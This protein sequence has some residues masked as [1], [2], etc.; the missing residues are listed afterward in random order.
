[1]IF[2]T[3]QQAINQPKLRI[4]APVAL[5]VGFVLFYLLN[6]PFDV[7]AVSSGVPFVCVTKYWDGI[8]GNLLYTKNA[9]NFQALLG[10]NF[11]SVTN[12]SLIVT[13][14]FVVFMLALVGFGYF[15]Y[16]NRLNL[17]LLGTAFINMYFMFANNV[18]QIVFVYIF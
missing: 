17:L 10:N 12:E 16:K 15:R 9:F 1:M 3:I 11:G 6:L 2:Y 13:I 5:V 7:N 4:A 18:R 8:F 14:V